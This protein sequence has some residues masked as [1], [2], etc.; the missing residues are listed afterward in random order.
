M[1]T[2]DF[3]GFTLLTENQASA[4][5]T[6]NEA[7]EALDA[8][9]DPTKTF[10]FVEDFVGNTSAAGSPFIEASSGTGA[11]VVTNNFAGTVNHPGVASLGTGSTNSGYATLNTRYASGL[12]LG[13]GA[14]RLTIIFRLE[15]LSDGTETYTIRLGFSDVQTGAD[16]TDGAFLRYTHSV[17]TG[18]FECVTR[19]NSTETA[20]DSGITVAADTW[21]KLDILV[22]AD[23]TE[24]EFRINDA[25]VATNT[26]DIPTGTGRET[27]ISMSILKSNGTTER[28]MY[29]DLAAATCSFTTQR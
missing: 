11:D 17:N 5:A 8:H 25:S 12:L 23:A 7:L 6:V 15:D 4:Q 19:S 9:L 3:L 29:V 26:T 21:Y 1:A 22:N 20:A 16:P 27:A 18:K 2:T 24:V 10:R 14:W 28:L 13:G